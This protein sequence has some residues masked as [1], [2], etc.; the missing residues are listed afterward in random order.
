MKEASV[1]CRSQQCFWKLVEPVGWEL[2]SVVCIDLLDVAQ[3]MNMFVDGVRDTRTN[4]RWFR[5]R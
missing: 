2:S 3:A 5:L 1:N 4:H